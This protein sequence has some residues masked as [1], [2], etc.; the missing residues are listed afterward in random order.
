M[1]V[2][3]P[4]RL[5]LVLMGCLKLLVLMGGGIESTPPPL[6][7]FVKTIEKVI[8]LCTVFIFFFEW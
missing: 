7:L 3:D 8:R 4:L 2:T 1:G 5:T 6:I